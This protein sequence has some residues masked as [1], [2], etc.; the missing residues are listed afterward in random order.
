MKSNG[1]SS[2]NFAYALVLV[3]LGL[4]IIFSFPARPLAA[5]GSANNSFVV[6]HT[7]VFDGHKVQPEADVWVEGGTIKA[8]GR[9]LK[10]PGGVKVIDGSGDTLLPGL[11]DS[12]THAWGDALKQALVFGVTTELDM[13]TSVQFMQE[14]KKEQA[15]GRALDAAD[16]FS[17]GT[18]ATAPGGHGTEYGMTIPTLSAPGDA[19][20]WVDARVAEGSDYIKIVLDDAST[21]GGHRPTLSQETLKAVVDAA[22]KDGKLAVVHIGS[23][24][25]ARD[26]INAGADGLVHLFS[27]SAPASDFAAFAAAHHVFIIPTLSVLESV[28]GT[29]SGKSLVDD[30][31]LEPFLDGDSK[32]SLSRGF[33]AFPT[34]PSELYAEQA[35]RE[36]KAAHVPILAGTDAPNPGTTHGASIHRELELLV[37]SGLTP[38]EALT[39]ATATPAATF[40]LKDRGEVAAGKRADLLLVKGDPTQDITATRDIV[41]VWKLGVAADRD[42]YRAAV[43]K[44]KDEAVKNAATAKSGS[45]LISNFDNGKPETNFGSGWVVSTDNIAGGKS[46]AEMK[47][48]PGGA[49]SDAY[50]MEISGVIDGG[51]P[52]AWGGVM[53]SP[54]SQVFAPVDL[55]AHKAITIWAKGDGQTYRAM[56]FTASGG[57]IPPQQTFVAGP[58]WKKYSFP[59]SGFNGSDGHDV[60]AILFVGG[61]GAGK[62][63]FKIDEVGLE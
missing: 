4:M 51:L 30:P 11:I 54:G 3:G 44:A 24:K 48:V 14:R 18:L 6:R 52:Y 27:D 12:H 9:D 39:A 21:Y 35:V 20:A 23:Q 19:Q 56:I 16:L 17:A 45:G 63:D 25:D 38:T 43:Q 41:S 32:A 22:H 40:H 2:K 8:I 28:S 5:A 62:F 60:S 10:V 15:E 46:T 49:N 36:L 57:R 1:S 53:F 47:I 31:R 37:R 50:A 59:F 29:A 26:A 55:S 33:P 7:R 42:G 58:E 61:P 34:H 13:F